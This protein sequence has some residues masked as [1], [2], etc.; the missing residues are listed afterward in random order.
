MFG[1]TMSMSI[2]L[3]LE[4]HQKLTFSHFQIFSSLDVNSSHFRYPSLKAIQRW[5]SVHLLSA[6]LSALHFSQ[7]SPLHTTSYILGSACQHS[8]SLY[9]PNHLHFIFRFWAL[10]PTKRW[11]QQSTG[12]C[13]IPCML[14]WS[15]LPGISRYSP[16]PKRQLPWVGSKSIKPCTSHNPLGPKFTVYLLDMNI[17]LCVTLYAYIPQ[18]HCSVFVEISPTVRP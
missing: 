13:T 10:S 15:R 4:Y 18:I 6:W 9:Y 8:M 3:P 7:P 11:R 17:L 12:L 2:F 14:G 1:L 16:L 5:C